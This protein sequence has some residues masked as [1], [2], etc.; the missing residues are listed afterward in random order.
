MQHLDS[1]SVE[2]SQNSAPYHLPSLGRAA[3]TFCYVR[4]RGDIVLA[5]VRKKELLECNGDAGLR[6]LKTTAYPVRIKVKLHSSGT[7][8]ACPPNYTGPRSGQRF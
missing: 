4:T 3:E 1:F 6:T 7:V 5:V 8:V 2:G